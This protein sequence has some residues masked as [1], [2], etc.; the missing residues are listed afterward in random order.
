MTHRLL[1]EF[2]GQVVGI[3][4]SE[5]IVAKKNTWQAI[6]FLLRQTG[7]GFVAL[8]GLEIIL[9]RLASLYLALR[10]KRDQFRY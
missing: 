1:T 8:K 5:V 2:P 6:W 7:L 4:A 10:G 9:G 3:V